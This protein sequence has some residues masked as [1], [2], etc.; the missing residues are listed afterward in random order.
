MK[1]FLKLAAVALI[2]FATPVV[3]FQVMNAIH[4]A[5]RPVQQDAHVWAYDDYNQKESLKKI[6][7]TMRAIAHMIER[8]AIT[9]GS[10]WHIDIDTD[11]QESGGCKSVRT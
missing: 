3:S 11:M 7:S 5:Y 10:N 6:C 4:E 9:A 8:E 2:A 1:T